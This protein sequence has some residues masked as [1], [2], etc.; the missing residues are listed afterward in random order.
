MVKKPYPFH[1]PF[2]PIR[3]L[4]R[5]TLSGRHHRRS[6][7]ATAKA[8]PV[9]PTEKL[10]GQ[11]VIVDVE[12]WLLMSRLS[13][14]PYFMLV[15]VEAG[16]FLRG[17]LLLLTYPLMCLFSHDMCLKAMIMVSFFGLRE[18][19]VLRVSKA[20]LPKLFL[21]DVAIQ[22]LEAVKKAR[23][24]VAV[25]TVFPR[26]MI[27]GF[28][29]EYLGVDTVVGREVM[30]VGGRYV[31]II[32]DDAVVAAEEMM[33]KG[34]YDEGVG[35]VGVGG[36]MHHLFSYRCKETYAV[37][38]ADKAAWQALPRDKYPK[39][40]VFHD[41]RLAFAPTFPAAIAMY[42]YI[43]F[44]IF[45]AIVR[46]MAYSLLPYRVSVPIG[47]LT[48]MRSRIIAGPPADAIEKDKAGG[49]LY[50][51]NHRTLLDPITVAAGLR[52]PVTAVT[53][54]VSPVS[55][56]MAPIRTARL[57]R[58]RDE[59]RRRMAGLLARGNLVVCPEGTTCRE[60]YLLRFSPLFTELAAEVTPVALE[61]RV[62]MFYGTSTKP[63]SKV[64]DPLYFM[65][66]PR[67]EYRVEFLEPV[68][69]TTV[70]DGEE[71][72]HDKSHSIHVANRVQRVLG[73]ALAFELTGQT[74]KDK[75]MM[76]AGNEGIVK[77][78]AK[79]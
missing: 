41:G 2:S 42:T 39:P 12:A 60:P 15:A 53:Y 69:T 26:V 76:L 8:T 48:G 24:V 23:K 70:A 36:K 55:E 64:L 47:A 14:F 3:R 17:L 1:K 73:E 66:N 59:D 10:Q 31:G 20:V 40:L 32:T 51:C 46:S 22:G 61:T 11:T 65:M 6:S 16:S 33:N 18:K 57:T 77:V 28:L 30:V 13:T 4:L 71:D 38:E 9:P 21:E 25:S 49:R 37:S 29:K 34:K 54:S 43:P 7:T 63:A 45:L 44:G 27:D 75:Y 58:D 78:K 67:P 19:E 79:K 72:G 56:L 62:D 52:K 35:L 5:R 74:R 50:V 68:D